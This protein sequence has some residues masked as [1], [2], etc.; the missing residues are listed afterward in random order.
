MKTYTKNEAKQGI[1]GLIKNFESQ[2]DV[3]KNTHQIDEA[4]LED[5]YIKPLFQLLNWNI[6]NDGL[7]LKE[8]ECIVQFKLRK[9]T[10]KKPDYLFQIKN[11]QSN[12]MQKCFFLEAKH[13]KYDIANHYGYI[14]QA[15]QYANSTINK[16]DN[17][18]N[19]VRLSILTNFETFILFDC[20]DPTPLKKEDIKFFNKQKLIEWNYKDFYEKFDDFWE[21]F[22][23]NN[24]INGS[25][26]KWKINEKELIER[27]DTPD[28]YFLSN[29]K[30]WRESIAQSMYRLDNNLSEET[31][32]E[33][34]QLIINRIIFVKAL[35][36][37]EIEE[38]YLSNILETLTS[39]YGGT[40]C[41]DRF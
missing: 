6:F 31:L 28:E 20:Y 16:A 37:R 11:V 35:S 36:D 25:L 30:E 5:Q 32:T 18:N 40:V 12:K 15:Y 41:Q 24:I 26:E 14:R 17:L 23:K 9:A 38:D 29:M 4:Q 33:A 39:N 3:I 34:S 27:R 2:I 1:K 8:R 21:I 13:P 22:E 7:S 10:T 19:V